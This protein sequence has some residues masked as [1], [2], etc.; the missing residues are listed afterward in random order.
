MAPVNSGEMGN[1]NP[2]QEKL[3][4]LLRAQQRT[5]ML[6]VGDVCTHSQWRPGYRPTFQSSAQ[7]R[8]PGSKKYLTVTKLGSF[9]WNGE[10]GGHPERLQRFILRVVCSC[11]CVA[12]VRGL[13]MYQSSGLPPFRHRGPVSWKT[14]FPWAGV[15]GCF[16]MIQAHYISCVL[17]F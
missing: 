13:G 17:Y 11:V 10:N 15:R 7:G 5:W 14:S 1:E 3:E 8:A 16:G 4:S 12:G 9:G 2:I 6:G